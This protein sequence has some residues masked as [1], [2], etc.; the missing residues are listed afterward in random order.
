M[1]VSR[2]VGQSCRQS[3]AKPSATHRPSRAALRVSA[4]AAPFPGQ[5]RS[6]DGAPPPVDDDTM[7]CP[8][9]IT[10][11]GKAVKALC[12][13]YGFRSGS[14]RLYQEDYGEVPK[15]AG[16]LA[17]SN[18][19]KE[20]EQMRRA[21]RGH[22]MEAPLPA[23]FLPATNRAIANVF[24]GLFAA[25]DVFLEDKKVLPVLKKEAVQGRLQ[26]EE[27]K[28][29]KAKLDRLILPTSA[30]VAYE[31]ERVARDGELDTPV[32][33]KLPFLLLCWVL[34]VVYDNKP[35]QKFWVL[36]VVAR[37][38]YFSFISILHLYESIG[39]WRAGAELR[40]I[41]F[42]EEWNEMHHLQIMESLGGD[43]LW[44]DRF[45]AEHAAIL[46][47]WVIIGF[48]LVNPKLA[49]NFMQRVEL[50]AADT[51]AVFLEQN[52]DL[53]KSMAP[54]AVA[55]NYYLGQDLY[56]FDEFQTGH[57]GPPRRPQCNTLHDTFANIYQDEMEHVKTMSSCQVR[58]AA[59][60]HMQRSVGQSV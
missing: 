1:K 40:R 8:I 23:G 16:E 9:F 30:V 20:L 39:F 5:S 46:Y 41:H 12:A 27:F 28:A 33:V 26:T 47:Y 4:I 36:E 43:Q 35:V 42:A 3:P 37:I 58:G 53:L 7:Q 44:F 2:N 18:F 55:L 17:Y 25:I 10:K 13:D 49:Y 11:E 34:D 14:G 32:W 19:E 52:K 29:V 24:V 22:D 60:A 6:Q 38:P 59:A 50:H 31:E 57:T 15:S 54:P 48:Y 21:F 51:Y 56:L 45:L